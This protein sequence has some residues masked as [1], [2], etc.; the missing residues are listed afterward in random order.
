MAFLLTKGN[1]SFLVSVNK[2]NKST[3][4][5]LGC[6]AETEGACREWTGGLLVVNGN[7]LTLPSKTRS[8]CENHPTGSTRWKFDESSRPRNWRADGDGDEAPL[9][10][11][12]GGI[13]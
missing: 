7:S 2:T 6:Q 11:T 12:G 4:R 3:F 8:A 10:T 5:A 13:G 9:G 1:T